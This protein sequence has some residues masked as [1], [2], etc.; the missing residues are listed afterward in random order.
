MNTS[1]SNQ[2][3]Q[4][5]PDG[6]GDALLRV[7]SVQRSTLKARR[8][9]LLFVIGLTVTVA[10]AA[11]ERLTFQRELRVV[12]DRLVAAE[13]VAGDL[14]L[15]DEQLTMSANMAVASGDLEW[16]DRYEA[17]LPLM[18]AAIGA[19]RSLA[20]TSMIE[21]LDLDTSAPN[22][23][24]VKLESAAINAVRQNNAAEGRRVLDSIEYQ[25]DKFVLNAG[26][27]RFVRGLTTSAQESAAA[28]ATWTMAALVV[29]VLV[30]AAAL[31]FLWRQ[32]VGSLVDSEAAFRLAQQQLKAETERDSFRA[33][34]SDALDIADNER[35][36]HE[37]IMRAMGMVAPQMPME[38]LL[39]DSSSANLERAAEHP[40]A[41]APGCGVDTP[42]SCMAVRRGNT[43][44]FA[45][46]E[47]LSACPRLRDRGGGRVSAVCVPVSF[48][49]RSLGVLHAATPAGESPVPGL[50]ARLEILGM[51]AG[52]RIGAVRAFA[53]TQLQASTDSL[54]GLANRR[55]VEE[56]VRRLLSAGEP[57][58]FVLADLDHF[59]MLNDKHGHAAG[60][61]A[62]RQYADV[63][64]SATRDGDLASRWGGEEFAI[65]FSGAD[66]ARA[67][68]V[69][70]R[71]RAM[72]A[73]ILGTS[74]SVVFT[75]SYG[76]ADS[77]MSSR[78]DHVLRMADRAMYTSKRLSRD[79]A[80]IGSASDLA[81]GSAYRTDQTDQINVRMLSELAHKI[82]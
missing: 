28:L 14:R 19:A 21:Q 31:T 40:M 33:Q 7:G 42:F 41:G 8:A 37:T 81:D 48:M 63:L 38:L 80:T 17:T 1:V 4:S 52:A 47:A 24:L 43:L 18:D 65:L 10:V 61:R 64:R 44:T 36:I 56:A 35:Q 20:T 51:L 72:L 26:T 60:D 45:D 73:T 75:A 55:T 23:R 22:D 68:E 5:A 67:L 6:S 58:A 57:Y 50:G 59:K 30:A 9:L 32:L 25:R 46:S 54:T 29:M 53:K 3:T 12:T 66:A 15:A 11:Y 62:L 76:I 77:T 71:I 49:G 34:L 39:S 69:V 79:R 16:I 27:E 70:E 78:F 82:G 74:G 2:S 13:K